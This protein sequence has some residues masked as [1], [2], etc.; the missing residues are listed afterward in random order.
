MEL[1]VLI[2]TMCSLFNMLIKVKEKPMIYIGDNCFSKLRFFIDGYLTCAQEHNDFDSIRNFENL[3]NYI[4]KSFSPVITDNS[5]YSYIIKSC[6]SEADAFDKFFVLFD[7][8]IA[9]DAE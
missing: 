3:K 2:K 6:K 7:E 8:F 5:Y 4:E 9:K 1:E